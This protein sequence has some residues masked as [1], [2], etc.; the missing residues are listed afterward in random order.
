MGLDPR[1]PGSLPELK[2][3]ASPTKPPRR[4]IR[5]IL[6]DQSTAPGNQLD[7]GFWSRGLRMTLA[8]ETKGLEASKYA[9]WATPPYLEAAQCRG[10][11]CQEWCEA[12]RE[13]SGTTPGNQEWIRAA[14]QSPR[15]N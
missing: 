8:L 9:S 5:S 11:G 13:P 7:V 2:A 4:P 12:R 10:G 3:D 14:S 15:G 1:T 6:E